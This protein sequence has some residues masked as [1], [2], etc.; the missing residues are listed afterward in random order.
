MTSNNF[1]QK[2]IEIFAEGLLLN[3]RILGIHLNGNQAE[4]D[5]LGFVKKRA[6]ETLD[7]S[8]VHIYA[9]LPD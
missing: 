2:E 3:H 8:T 9:R 1:S 7:M 4:I 6:R 5:K